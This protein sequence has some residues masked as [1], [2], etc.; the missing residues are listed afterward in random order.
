[1]ILATRS[2]LLRITAGLL[3]FGISFG[4]VEAAVV[5]YL[6]H[7][8]APFHH[9]DEGELFPLVDR[10]QLEK[11]AP[12]VYGLLP[13]EVL[14]EAA[15]IAMLAAIALVVVRERQVWL[16]CFAIVFGTWDLFFYVFL[17][18]LVDWP[19]SLLTWD[20]LFLIPVPWVAPVLAP[21]LV[22][23]TI[24]GGGLLGLWRPIRLRR[25]DWVAIVAGCGI[26]LTSFMWDAPNV[27][28]GGLPRP[29]LWPVFAVGETLGI[30]ALL[31][32]ARSESSHKIGGA[33]PARHQRT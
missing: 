15:T 13:V 4:F 3:L 31:H 1:M 9:S 25:L 2:T 27:L 24:T 23:L 19:A 8:S 7:I 26:I 30:A 28:S 5:I 11:E 18:L 21:V 6:R 14:R 22:S 17:K 16:A 32:A 12:A 29:F 10:H 33:I 20:I